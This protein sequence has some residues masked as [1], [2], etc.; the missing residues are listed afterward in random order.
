MSSLDV[1]LNFVIPKTLKNIF[2]KFIFLVKKMLLN[3]DAKLNTQNTKSIQIK[4]ITV[5]IAL[6]TL[7]KRATMIKSLSLLF[8]K[9]Q[10]KLFACD[11]SKW[12]SKTRDLL[13]KSLFSPCFLQFFT[14]FPTFMPNSLQLLSLSLKRANM[15]KLLPIAHLKNS[16]H[17]KELNKF[18]LPN[19][20]DEHCLF[21]CIYPSSI[22]ALNQKS[23]NIDDFTIK[24]QQR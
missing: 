23:K 12:I 15:S 19:D 18:C 9:E 14:T 20:S 1:I 11:S 6:V 24:I 10:C 5:R 22:G 17:G 21:F 4:V 8:K 3:F 13:K 2:L 16:Q 7:Y